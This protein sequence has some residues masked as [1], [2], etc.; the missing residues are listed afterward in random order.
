MRQTLEARFWAKVQKT[1]GC[2]LWVGAKSGDGYGQIW[3][4]GAFRRAHRLSWEI[5]NDLI[6][7]G[8]GYH[9]T[10]VLHTCDVPACVNPNHLFLGTPA[11]NSADMATKGRAAGGDRNGRA[12]LTTAQVLEIHSRQSQ[13]Q[14]TLAKDFGVSKTQIGHIRS[15][16]RW[17]HLKTPGI[18]R[19]FEATASAS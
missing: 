16:K 3:R 10:C 13:S 14:R 9:G 1:D 7:K 17:T 18:T 4:D 8:N 12:R 5:H 2:W 15:G 19:V 6:P 11:D